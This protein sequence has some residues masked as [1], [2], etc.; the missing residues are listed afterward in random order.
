MDGFGLAL[1]HAFRSLR[2]S[3]GF[4]FVAVFTLA[5]GIGATT[6]VYSILDAVV[7]RPLPCAAP[8]RMVL[9]VESHP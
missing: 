9:V 4:T 7:L 6:L 8:D 2:A 1:R 5:L 3:P